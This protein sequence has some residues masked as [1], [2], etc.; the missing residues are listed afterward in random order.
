MNIYTIHHASSTGGS[1][2]SQV[3]SAATNSILI[4]EINP[5]VLYPRNKVRFQPDSILH[6]LQVNSVKLDDDELLNFFI[7]QMQVAIRHSS[8]LSKNILLRDHSHSTFNFKNKDINFF[9]EKWSSK[10]T[11]SLDEFFRKIDGYNISIICPILTTRHPLDSYISNRSNKWLSAYC[12]KELGIDQYCKSLLKFQ[13]YF[14]QERDA[15]I[16][17]YE[18]VCFDIENSLSK[19][20]KKLNTEY[21]IPTL[22]QINS[23]EVSGKSGRKSTKIATRPRKIDDCDEDLIKSCKESKFYNLYCEINSYDS[24]PR[25]NN[26]NL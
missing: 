13:Q 18:D 15:I 7:Y 26:F 8:K 24:N 10:F 16:I 25:S 22:D 5:Y 20:F 9:N 23:I 14:V 19:F 6:H 2:L 1:I 12:S 3:L 4:S 21:K 11:Y 17:K